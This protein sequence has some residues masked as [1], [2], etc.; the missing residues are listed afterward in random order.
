MVAHLQKASAKAGTD[1][2]V[3]GKKV[4][5]ELAGGKKL[6]EISVFTDRD[7]QHERMVRQSMD[8]LMLPASRMRVA[9]D[10]DAVVLVICSA[11][12]PLIG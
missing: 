1:T 7:R 6:K 12:S 4:E 2:F 8:S 5:K 9:S 11:A 10:R 3:W